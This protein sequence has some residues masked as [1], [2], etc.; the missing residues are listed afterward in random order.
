MGNDICSEAKTLCGPDEPAVV[1]YEYQPTANP[2]TSDR[3]RTREAVREAPEAIPCLNAEVRAVLAEKQ[4]ALVELLQMQGLLKVRQF[5][6]DVYEGELQGTVPH[7]IG[8][9]Y[10][11]DGSLFVGRFVQ[12]RAEGPG[13]YVLPDGAY[14]EGELVDN[15]AHCDHGRYFNRLLTYEGG[16]RDNL[17]SGEGSER[18]ER[19]SFEGTYEG[20]VR[21]CG[22]LRWWASPGEENQYC[23]YGKFDADGLFTED[24]TLREPTGN[25]TGSFL[26]GKKHGEGTYIYSNNLKYEGEYREGVKHGKGRVSFADKLSVIYEGEFSSGLPDGRGV[27]YEEDGSSHSALFKQGINVL[28]LIDPQSLPN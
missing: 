10:K 2:R 8:R 13:L 23:Y 4:A 17:F 18:S 9:M 22:E 1:I 16:F 15:R 27:K 25:Y 20:G 12:G 26:R 24:G 14:F 28:T 19:H 11:S 7:G 6:D 3:K 21:R 5:G